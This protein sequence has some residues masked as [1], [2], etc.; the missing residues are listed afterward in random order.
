MAIYHL[1]VK[2]I[3]RNTGRSAVAAA[4][5]RAGEDIKNEKDGF[6]HKY[7]GRKDVVYS[8][9]LLPENAPEQWKQRSVLWNAV[10]QIEKRKDARTAREVEVALPVEFSRELQKEVL[11]Q[12]C[13]DNFVS[14]GMVAD[15]NMH[16][17]GH[18]NPHA[19]IL[20]TTRNIENQ[21]FAKKN[22]EWNDKARLQAW[23]ENWAVVCNQYLE[24]QNKIDHRSFED[25]GKE[26]L[27]QIHEGYAARKMEEKGLI[28]DRCEIN[29]NIMAAN[30]AIKALENQL[31]EI[32]MQIESD[33][34]AIADLQEKNGGKYNNEVAE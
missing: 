32:Q 19:H 1:S 18:G 14:Q 16:D 20:L 7:S 5:Y 17:K 34:R 2:I 3:S 21:Q 26:A 28:A 9:V 15:V 27:P 11:K 29:R 10:E 31:E 6:T 22:R 33:K 12:F 25:Q 8:E 30:E 23:R 13:Q 4:A 24:E